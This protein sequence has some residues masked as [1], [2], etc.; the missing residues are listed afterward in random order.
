M[1]T[2]V[3]ILEFPNE[4]KI[5]LK[6][7]DIFKLPVINSYCLTIGVTIPPTTIEGENFH[8]TPWIKAFSQFFKNNDG[9][10]IT[11]RKIF[12]SDPE[13]VE[14]TIITCKICET[15][16]ESINIKLNKFL[17]LLR[18]FKRQNALEHVTVS[19]D[20]KELKLDIQIE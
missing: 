2:Q 7:E 12:N 13:S 10:D 9:N 14:R 11:A 3:F 19:I 1:K 17:V 15:N 8:N 18:E 4:C 20:G 16:I 5:S 6:T